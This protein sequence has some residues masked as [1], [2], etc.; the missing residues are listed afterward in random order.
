MRIRILVALSVWTFV[1]I[2]A[3]LFFELFL[4]K[5]FVNPNKGARRL[6][7][8]GGDRERFLRNRNLNIVQLAASPFLVDG[9]DSIYKSKELWDA[10][11]IVVQSHKLVFFS[12]PK[13]GCTTFKQLLRRMMGFRDW[14][15]Q[16]GRTFMPHNPQYNGL[17][18]LYDFSLEE[19]NEIMTS[20]NYTRAIFVRDPKVGKHGILCF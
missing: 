14:K 9:N 10:S 6:I 13:A 8:I 18:Y 12:I 2:N 16:N 3:I 19:A 7:T 1:A 11:P 15:S 17:R 5:S 4:F 20:P